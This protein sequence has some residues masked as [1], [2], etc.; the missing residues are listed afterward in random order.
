VAE[1]ALTTGNT[2]DQTRLKPCR[3]QPFG[4]K[5]ELK[6]E[7]KKEI[8]VQNICAAQKQQTV[9]P[10]EAV[11]AEEAWAKLRKNG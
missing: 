5:A 6:S 8:P 1:A 4:L 11:G 9:G 10:N 2:A 3:G 7:R